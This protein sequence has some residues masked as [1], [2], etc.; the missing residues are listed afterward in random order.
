MQLSPHFKL[1]EFTRNSRGFSNEPPADVV[2]RLR[3]LCVFVLEPVRNRYNVPI[4]VTSGYREPKL[5]KAVGGA[6][7]SAHMAEDNRCAADIQLGVKLRVVFDWL[8]STNIPYDTIILER[9]PVEG[10][11]KDDCLHI[12]ISPVGR[13]RAMLGPTHGKG[14]YTILE[15]GNA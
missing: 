9:G 10:S 8:R 5:N 12:Q 2:E 1:E 14:E 11:E 4:H 15:A 7:R 6:A 3:W 13:R